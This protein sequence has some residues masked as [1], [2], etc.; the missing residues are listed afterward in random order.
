MEV[1]ASQPGLVQTQLNMRKLDH[2]KLTANLVDLATR[3]YGQ[4]ADKASLCLQRPASD[5]T[6]DGARPLPSPLRYMMSCLGFVCMIECP[7]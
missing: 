1:F 3:V 2:G 4:R 7:K 6:V 5:P